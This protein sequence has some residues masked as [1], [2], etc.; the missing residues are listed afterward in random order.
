[1][2]FGIINILGGKTV[3]KYLFHTAAKPQPLPPIL[4]RQL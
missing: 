4:K 3:R 1:M 2:N